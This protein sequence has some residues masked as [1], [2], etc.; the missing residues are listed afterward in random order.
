VADRTAVTRVTAMVAVPM[1]V[2]GRMAAHLMV[3]HR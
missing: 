2:Q 1:V 3:H